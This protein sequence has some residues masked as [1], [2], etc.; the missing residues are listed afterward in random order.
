MHTDDNVIDDEVAVQEDLGAEV[1]PEVTDAEPAGDRPRIIVK[2]S[3]AETDEVFHVV[4]PSVIGR[5]DPT[6]GPVD[7]DLGNLAESVYVSRKH[8]RISCEDWVWTIE[9]LGSSN[10]TF[11]LRSDFERIEAAELEDG[12]EFA[13]GNARFIFRIAECNQ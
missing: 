12:T 13:L 6:V 10:G 3:G 4:S 8:A 5:F 7:V 11:V 1:A 9:D 2:R